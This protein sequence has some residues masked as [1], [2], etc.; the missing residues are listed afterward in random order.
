MANYNAIARVSEELIETLQ[1]AMTER[2]DVISLDPSEIVLASPDDVSSNTDIRLS[3]YLYK[4]EQSGHQHRRPITNNDTRQSP[5]LSLT[6]HYLLTAYPSST[7]ANETTN[8]SDQ[9]NA[10]GLAMQALYDNSVLDTEALGESFRDERTL[11]IS[12]DSDSE[13]KIS[14]IW[15]SFRDVPLYPSVT[16]QVGPVLIDSRKEEQIQRVTERDF[17]PT[18]KER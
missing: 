6:L 13:N 14:R 18:Q 2:D 7:G 10:L 8:M 9:H 1:T 4:V 12:M 15:D 16:Y 11:T 5:P 3:L 17:R